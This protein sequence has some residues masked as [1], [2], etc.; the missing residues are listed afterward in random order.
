MSTTAS[1]LAALLA[2]ASQSA[3]GLGALPPAR[4]AAALALDGLTISLI[5]HS[6]LELVWSDP[7]DTPGIALDDLQYTLGEGPTL[8]AA[9]TG[10]PT[11]VPDLHAMPETRWPALLP[12]LHDHPVRAVFALPLHLGVIRLGVLTG[13]RGTPGPLHRAQ[14]TDALALAEAATVIL[15]TPDGVHDIGSNDPLPLHR[16]LIHQ[17]TGALSYRLGVSLTDALA[18]L[19][20][21]AY[22]NDRPILDVAHDVIH[23]RLHLGSV[24]K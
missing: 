12:A 9:H 8:D 24:F 16:A 4:C 5:N 3:Q 13:R 10:R 21:Y 19:R 17:A 2:A 6:G 15:L 23:H 14:M 20:A 22:T 7:A 18:R 11:I 1:D